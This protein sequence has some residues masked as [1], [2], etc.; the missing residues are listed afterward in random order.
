[1]DTLK[2]MQVFVAV[3]DSGS[4]TA[5]AD[6]LGLSRPVV[7]RY[8]AELE[9]WTGARLL[10]RTTRKL[11]VTAAGSETLQRCRQVLALTDDMQSAVAV[12]DSTPQGL[13]RITVSTSFGQLHLAGA[14][15]DF[16]KRYPAVAIDLVM[17]DRAVNLVEERID[18]AV[19]IASTLDPNLIARRLTVCRSAVCASPD[20]LRTHPPLR[21]MEDLAAHNCLTHSYYGKTLWNYERDGQPASVAVGGNLSANESTSLLQAALAGVGVALLPT[22]MSAPLVRS[23]QLVALLPEV[24]QR[25]LSIYAVYSSRKN[26]S[27]ALR[28]L[29][30]FLAERFPPEPPWDAVA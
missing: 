16:V 4:Q 1:M 15:A 21:R 5:A 3:V 22:F 18:L 12:P 2:A 6:V 17:L 9:G 7:S 27:T 28:T 24:R 19:R 30:D 13:L 20:Y 23:G 26:M 25:E 11:S 10:H 8:I 14:V 29:L